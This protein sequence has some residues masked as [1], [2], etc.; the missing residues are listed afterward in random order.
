MLPSSA[1]GGVA[2]DVYQ[3]DAQSHWAVCGCG[4]IMD[5]KDHIN[6]NDDN[7]CDICGYLLSG[8]EAGGTAEPSDPTED[9][10]VWVWFAA[11][12]ITYPQSRQTSSVSSVAV[13]LD[14]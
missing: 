9:A 4:E 3:H 1:C 7:K 11:S 13:P 8:G 10:A 12:V 6:S 2:L 5:K 14:L